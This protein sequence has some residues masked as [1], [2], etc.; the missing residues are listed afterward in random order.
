VMQRSW[1]SP[2]G[3]R[4]SKFNRPDRGEQGGRRSPLDT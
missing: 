2:P 4:R 3:T 1:R